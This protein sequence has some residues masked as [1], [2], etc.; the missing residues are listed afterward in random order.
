MNT[1]SGVLRNISAVGEGVTPDFF[2]RG[3]QQILFRTEGL[4]NGDLG[5]VAP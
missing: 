2:S 4:E 3:V 1:S 5:A